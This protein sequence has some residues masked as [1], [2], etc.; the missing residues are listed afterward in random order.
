MALETDIKLSVTEPDI[1][2]IFFA[3][4]NWENGPK[5]EFFEFIEKFGL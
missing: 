2:E 3:S 5:S 1:S 4:H